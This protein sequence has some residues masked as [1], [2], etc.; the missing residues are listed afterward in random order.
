MKKLRFALAV[1]VKTPGL[2]PIKTRLAKSIGES[3]ALKVYQK[4]LEMTQLKIDQLVAESSQILVP[5]WAVAE[6][7]GLTAAHWKSWNRIYQ[8]EGELGDRLSRVYEELLSQFDGV[9]LMGADSPLFPSTE[10]NDGISWLANN[11]FGALVGPT[12]DGGYYAFGFRKPVPKSIWTS[13]PY[14]T[15]TTLASF[16]DLLPSQIEKN[17][18]SK[19][20]DVDTQ[21]DLRRLERE[22]PDF[23]KGT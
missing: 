23:M 14:S 5:Y 11:E 22:V 2:S 7:E 9:I 4:C 17:F 1:F 13:V 15:S 20:W 19:H 16:L 8:G 18:L 6:K 21:D 12:L 10:I 3:Q